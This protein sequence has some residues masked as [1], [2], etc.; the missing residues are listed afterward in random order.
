ML[1]VSAAAGLRVSAPAGTKVQLQFRAALDMESAWADISG[2]RI[3]LGTSP[4]TIF[5]PSAGDAKPGF[6]R[7]VVVP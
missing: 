7:V 2:K 6:Y 1:A 4:V 3:T 5:S